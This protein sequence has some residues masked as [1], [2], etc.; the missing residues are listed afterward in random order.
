MVDLGRP[1][2]LLSHGRRGGRRGHAGGLVTTR[3]LRA[4]AVLAAICIAVSGAC[5][6]F[7]V[8]TV[9]AQQRQGRQAELKICTTLARIAALRPPAGNPALN[10]SRA[11]DQRLHMTLEQLG[12]DLGCVTHAHP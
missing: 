5:L 1:H 9:H 12:P 4:A 6:L 10:P 3:Q 2:R 11:Y 7:T 8:R